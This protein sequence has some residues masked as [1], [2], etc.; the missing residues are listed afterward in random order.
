MKV[1]LNDHED[2]CMFSSTLQDLRHKPCRMEHGGRIFC[3]KGSATLSLN[4]NIY[5][6]V[7]NTSLAILPHCLLEVID[8]SDDFESFLFVYT[9]EFFQV[10]SKDLQGI[11][12]YYTA[13]PF[14]IRQE[15]DANYILSALAM[16]QK[17]STHNEYH[18]RIQ[19]AQCIL[20]YFLMDICSRSFLKSKIES[21]RPLLHI[22]DYFNHFMFQLTEEYKKERSVKYYSA[23]LY[24][25]PKHLNYICKRIANSNAKEVINQYLTTQLKNEISSSDKTISEISYAFNFPSPACLGRYFKKQTGLTPLDFREKG[26]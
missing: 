26:K 20:R 18:Y 14:I 10:A 23:S 9:T 24:I 7:K 21:F 25:S 16:L 13:H 1:T 6:M 2:F 19:M 15:Q 5:Y 4:G 8:R 3:I 17:L 11:L 12:P 22:D